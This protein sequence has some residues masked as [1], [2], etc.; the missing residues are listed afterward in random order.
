LSGAPKQLA[1]LIPNPRRVL[2]QKQ[3]LNDKL[4]Q[5]HSLLQ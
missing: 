3:D 5:M 1:V 2:D 4:Q